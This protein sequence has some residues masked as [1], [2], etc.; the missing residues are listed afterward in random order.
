MVVMLDDTQK[1]QRDSFEF[2]TSN[3]QD[4]DAGFHPESALFCRGDAQPL[5][6]Y[7]SADIYQRFGTPNSEPNRA[8]LIQQFRDESIAFIVESFRLNQFPV[9]VRRFWADNYQ[10]YR[11]SVFVAGRRLEGRGGSSSVFEIVAPGEYRWLPTAGPQPITLDGQSLGAGEIIDLA[12]GEHVAGF[13]EDGPGGILVLA[14]EQPP[15]LAPLAFY[16]AN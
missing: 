11:A 12:S 2:I 1:V 8:R 9:E 6:H 10:P 15:G 13:T 14:L 4:S 3:F 5:Q 16:T 7:F